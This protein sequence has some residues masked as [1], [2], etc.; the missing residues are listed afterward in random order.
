M[1]VSL[2][3]MVTGCGEDGG[4]E[5]VLGFG[6]RGLDRCSLVSAEEA[7]QWLGGPVNVGPT[8][9]IDGEPDL[10]TCFYEAENS[11]NS[12]LVQ[13]YDGEIFFAEEGSPS[14]TGETLDG[15]GD[16]AWI[17][18]GDI[19]FLQNDWTVSVSLI[20]GRVTDEDLLAMAELISS[21]LP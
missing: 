1:A 15:L 4:S 17:E 3:L 16:D 7:E 20:L 8:E 21:R 18:A 9:G 11:P 12:I 19:N 5:E 6:D 2:T 14:R 13:V 10:I